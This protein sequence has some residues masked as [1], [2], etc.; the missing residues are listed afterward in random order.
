MISPKRFS[1]PTLLIALAIGATAA[2][3]DASP[4][5]ATADDTAGRSELYQKGQQAL[6]AGKFLEA[7]DLFDRLA[8]QRGAEAD[9]ALYWKAYASAKAGHKGVAL[10][11]IRTLRS[12]Y[13]ESSW[14][15]D[16]AALELSLRDSGREDF[17]RQLAEVEREA[18]RAVERAQ[19]DAERAGREAERVGR[20]AERVARDAERAARG[21]ARSASQLDEKDELKLYALNGLMQADPEKAVPVLEKFLQAEQSPLLKERALFVLSQSDSP[22]AREILLDFARNGQPF[23][24]R[25]KAIQMFGIAG[26]PEDLAVLG[27]LYRSGSPEVRSAILDAWMIADATAPVLAAAKE[28]K[29]AALRGRAIEL[30]GVMDAQNALGELWARESDPALKRRLLDAF[31]I[32]GNAEMLAKAARGEKDPALRV[33]AI[34][35]LGLIDD[36]RAGRE[37]LSIYES[38]PDPKAKRAVLDG[39]MLRDDAATLIALFRKE[40]DPAL[41]REIVQKL[42][43]LDSDEAADELARLLEEKP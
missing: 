9:A 17:E 42:S 25:A 20:E 11:A 5:Y 39:L 21:A 10:D 32:S 31:A 4:P 1:I 22:R 33:K 38:S 36:E 7:A 23:E 43:M 29:D 41:K 34:Q 3:A 26:E 16:A 18:E 8:A 28:E 19:R 2:A 13:P 12:T 27:S 15:D 37:L 35:G 6:S 40:T 24:L 14:D 30:L